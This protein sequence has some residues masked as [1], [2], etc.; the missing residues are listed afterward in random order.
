MTLQKKPKL[1]IAQYKMI[2]ACNFRKLIMLLKQ[3]L[4]ST[5]L[6]QFKDT[7]KHYKTDTILVK[8]KKEDYLHQVWHIWIFFSFF[9][10]Q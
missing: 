2:Q 3:S 8:D 4:F 7:L 10:I 6:L 5:L 1:F 9:P